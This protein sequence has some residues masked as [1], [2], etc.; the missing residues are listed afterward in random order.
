[1]DNLHYKS[2]YLKKFV[3]ISYV[4]AYTSFVAVLS[5]NIYN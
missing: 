1:M 4:Y 2:F 3:N 5:K